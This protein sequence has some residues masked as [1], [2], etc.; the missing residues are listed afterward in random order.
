MNNA[1]DIVEASGS[2]FIKALVS[3]LPLESTAV[4]IYE[5]LQSKQIER[6]IHRFEEF[7]QNL[8]TTVNTVEEKINSEYVKKDDFLDVFERAT[9]YVISER[10]ERKRILF[11]NILANSIVSSVCDYDKTERYFRLLDN[12][13]EIELKVLAVLDNP[14]EYNRSHGMI[15][16]DSIQDP[17]QT[18]LELLTAS[19]VLTQLLSI[20]VD[21]ASAAVT[22]LFSNG[23]IIERFLGN[24]LHYNGNPVRVLNNLLTE[25][26]KDFVNFLKEL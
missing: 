20:H 6:K 17:H 12:L 24:P 2:V 11:K 15:I 26:G 3:C 25:R 7:C 21:E 10:Q 4:A 1:K 19:G 18:G 14:V 16:P 9:Q 22:V 5:E 23:L 13:S 8:V